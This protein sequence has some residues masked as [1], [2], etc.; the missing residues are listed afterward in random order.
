MYNFASVSLDSTHGA[1]VTMSQTLLWRHFW[2]GKAHRWQWIT[3]GRLLAQ[4]LM[5]SLLWSFSSTGVAV[6]EQIIPCSNRGKKAVLKKKK[7]NGNRNRTSSN[8]NTLL[9]IKRTPNP[10]S[11]WS[12]IQGCCIRSF[13]GSADAAKGRF[14]EN[15]LTTFLKFVCDENLG[16]DVASKGQSNYAS[17]S[18]K[19]FCLRC[20]LLITMIL[21]PRSHLWDTWNSH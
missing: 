19:P 7:K 5:W 15:N 10:Q 1:C 16:P 11:P 21:L 14:A 4:L 6:V 12:F 17:K 3:Q 2:S 9:W 18:A 20:S 8:S 13:G